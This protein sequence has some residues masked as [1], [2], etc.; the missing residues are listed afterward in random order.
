MSTELQVHAG[1]A[2]LSHTGSWTPEQVALVRNTV[3]KGA[4]EDEFKFFLAVCGRTGLDPFTKQIYLVK[5]WDSQAG[6]DVMAIQTGIDGY[7]LIAQRSA[8][9]QGQVGPWWCGPDGAWREIWTAAEPPF[10]AKVGIW[11]KGF[12][13][14]LYSTARWDAYV[15]TKK[16]GKPNRFWT[17][18]GPEQLAKCA[19]ALVLRKAFPNELSGL[20]TR[21]EMGQAD[22]EAPPQ[23]EP[24]RAAVIETPA[25][26]RDWH[27][28]FVDYC[29]S[30]G[31]AGPG[32]KRVAVNLVGAKMGGPLWRPVAEGAACPPTDSQFYE[33]AVLWVEAHGWPT[34]E[35]AL[36][37]S[38]TQAAPGDSRIEETYYSASAKARV[39]IKDMPQPHLLAAIQKL[40]ASLHGTLA[41]DPENGSETL[42]ALMAERDRRAERAEKAAQA[43]A[44]AQAATAR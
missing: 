20:Y 22:N 40:A 44:E 18:M 9:Y 13:E 16:D 38:V 24:S 28:E 12:R 30:N 33:S 43:A 2:A 1:A 21:E 32:T 19:E 7:R 31:I 5:R 17:M 25:P 15:Q 27:V 10:A 26:E 23:R 8:E 41:A 29:R 6:K 37:A 35:Q 36:A 42:D 11:R 14:P 4:T 39:Q 34:L 3:A